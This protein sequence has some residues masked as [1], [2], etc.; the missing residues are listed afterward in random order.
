MLE[1]EKGKQVLKKTGGILK[2][3]EMLEDG[4]GKRVCT[5]ADVVSTRRVIGQLS[6]VEKGINL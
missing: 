4:K 6:N 1:D 3:K 2:E 5:Y